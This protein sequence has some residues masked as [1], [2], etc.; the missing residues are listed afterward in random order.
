MSLLSFEIYSIDTP[1]TIEARYHESH[2]K[3]IWIRGCRDIRNQ[4][5]YRGPKTPP[6]HT[7]SD[8][9]FSSSYQLLLTGYPKWNDERETPIGYH[10]IDYVI[11]DD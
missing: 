4:K 11:Q 8:L 7:Y 10:S 1:Q 2:T 6:P 3:V 5:P 9:Y